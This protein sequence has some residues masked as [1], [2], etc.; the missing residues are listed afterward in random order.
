MHAA[1][2]SMTVQDVQRCWKPQSGCRLRE[3]MSSSPAPLLHQLA[4]FS[5]AGVLTCCVATLLPGSTESHVALKKIRLEDDDTGVPL[6]AIREVASLKCLKHPNVVT[7]HDTV[8]EVSC[9]SLALR[10]AHTHTRAR[11]HTHTHTRT[12]THTH[13]HAHTHVCTQQQSNLPAVSARAK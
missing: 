7:L 3:D 13:T 8:L 12:H 11:A 10:D 1:D 4:F 5:F 6:S 2:V 9:V